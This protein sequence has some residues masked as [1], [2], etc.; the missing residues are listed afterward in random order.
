[1]GSVI[2]VTSL[3][4]TFLAIAD[5]VVELGHGTTVAA[6]TTTERG[7]LAGPGPQFSK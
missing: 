2:V 7:L 5:H 3:S 4:R 1:M 6:A